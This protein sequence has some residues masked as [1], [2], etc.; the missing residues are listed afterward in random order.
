MIAESAWVSCH[1]PGKDIEGHRQWSWWWA[2]ASS[3]P[4][5]YWDTHCPPC[6]CWDGIPDGQTIR[7]PFYV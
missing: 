2:Q 7:K 4:W 3:P 5:G 6:Q 1:L